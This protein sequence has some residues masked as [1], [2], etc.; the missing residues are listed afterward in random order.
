MRICLIL[1]GCYPYVTGGV[2][3][4]T[5]Q[6]IGALPEH[7]F[8]LWTIGAKAEDRGKF[9]YTLPSNVVETHELFLDDALRGRPGRG[10]VRF[11]EEEKAAMSQFVHCADPDWGVL[12]DVLRGHGSS[13]RAVTPMGFLMSETFL[14]LICDICR[15]DYPYTAFSDMFHTMRSMLLPLLYVM[16]QDVPRADIYH[17]IAAGYSGI[18]A[19]LGGYVHRA[20]IIL[21]EHGIYSR[22]R[23]EEIIRAQWVPPA[24]KRLWVRF[25]NMLSRAVYDR[26]TV[27]TSLFGNA[28]RAQIDLGCDSAK[29]RITPNGVDVERFGG[30]P[31]KQP[32]GWVDIGAVVR[33][34]PIKDVKTL[35]YAFAELKHRIDNVRL[36][37]I[38]PEDDKEYANECYELVRQ[39]NIRDVIFTGR[40]DVVAYLAKV[41]FT[42]LTSI[43]EGQPLSVLESY[44]AGRPCVLTD[45]GC[46]RELLDGAEGDDLGCAGYCVEPMNRM[47]LCAALERMCLHAD[48]RLAMGEVGRARVRTYFRKEQMV[49]TYRDLYREVGDGWRA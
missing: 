28:R 46:C 29:C 30:V 38:G 36:H 5:H 7:E 39:L 3:S 17:T 19:C 40:V 1:E 42:V 31:P 49:A 44:A 41:D 23:E 22:E 14:D 32:D 26:A 2:S 8:V 21:S 37:V 18:L 16:S 34:A 25:F 6:L 13:G 45:V 43:S 27:V 48:D 11:S 10:K 9:V 20:P 47:A 4:W 35:L 33:L 24:F 12:F 15:R